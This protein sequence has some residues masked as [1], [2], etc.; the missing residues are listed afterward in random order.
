MNESGGRTKM[1][2]QTE[3]VLRMDKVPLVGPYTSSL[4]DTIQDVFK[5]KGSDT[6]LGITYVRGEEHLEVERKSRAEKDSNL[7]TPFA[8]VRA[9][10]DMVVQDEEG[11]ALRLLCLALQLLK[12]EGFKPTFITASVSVSKLNIWAG[13]DV[14]K[15][16]GIRVLSDPECPARKVFVCGST[17]GS[18]LGHVERCVVINTKGPGNA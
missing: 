12:T 10:S 7:L 3:W 17:Q 14:A 15:L 6:I 11:D 4:L 2:Q 9:Q 8:T 5:T 16:F 1:D 13:L 18:L